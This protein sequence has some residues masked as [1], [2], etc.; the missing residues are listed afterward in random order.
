MD[1]VDARKEGWACQRRTY[2]RGC[3]VEGAYKARV[4]QF[5]LTSSAV[6][7]KSRG[8][9]LI[10]NLFIRA[11]SSIM[12]NTIHGRYFSRMDEF[13]RFLCQALIVSNGRYPV[14]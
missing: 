1:N 5:R 12:H 14:C 13:N 4:L 11:Y 8:A 3:N 9:N 7:T 6:V 2:T 10:E